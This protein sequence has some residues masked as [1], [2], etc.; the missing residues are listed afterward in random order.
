MVCLPFLKT[1][2]DM[3]NKKNIENTFGSQSFFFFF[4]QDS[5]II[6][7][8]TYVAQMHYIGQ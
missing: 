7:V 6:L 5:D 4:V 2:F 3:K 1:V 8:V